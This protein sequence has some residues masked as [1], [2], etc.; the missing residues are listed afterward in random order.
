MSSVDLIL[1]AAG[2]MLGVG[3]LTVLA[4]F[5]YS[6]Y[7]NYVERRLATRKGLYRDLVA[8]LANR[9]RALLEPTIHQMSTLYDLDALEAVL[10]EQARTSTGRPAWLLEVYDQLGLVDKYID[11]LR[12]ARKWRDRAFAAELLGRVGSAKAVPALLETVQA[13]QTEDADVREIALRALARI[14]DPQAVGPLIAALANADPWL[15]PRIADILARH[16]D[17]VV[18]PLLTLLTDS[19]RHPARVW[20]AN[21]LGEVRAQRAFPVLVR[22]LDDP[23]DEVRAKSATALGRLGDRR[24][25]SPLLDHLLTDPAPFV[26]VRIACTLGD[27]G[28]SEVVNRLVRALGDPAWWVRMRGVEALEQI[29][30]A[31]EGPLLLALDDPDPEIRKRAAASLERLGVPA[32][33]LHSIE[34]EEPSEE[35]SRTLVRLASASSRELVAELLRHPS[36]RVRGLMLTAARESHRSDLAP[37]IARVATDDP[38]PG[39]R[40]QAFDTLARVRSRG[41]GRSALKG[42]A[43]PDPEVRTAAIRLLGEVGDHAVLDPLRHATRDPEPTIRAAAA[44][45]LGKIGDRAAEPDFLRLL[46][47]PDSKVRE[48]A[49]DGAAEAGIQSL[50]PALQERLTDSEGPV[51]G[52]ELRTALALALSRLD[53]NAATH[54]V[55]RLAESSDAASRIAA[56]RLLGR[57]RLPSGTPQWERL[58]SDGEPDVRAA[59]LEALGRDARLSG[60]SDILLRAVTAGLSDSSETVRARAIDVCSRKCLDEHSRTLTSLLQDDPAATVR[61]RA[62]LAL[63]LL[64]AHG[65]ETVLTAACRR[66]QSPDVRAA[67]ALAAGAYDRNSLVTLMLEMPDSGAVRARLRHYLKADPW[68]RLLSRSLPRASEAELRALAAD[69]AVESQVTLATGVR[70]LLSASERVRLIT[71]LQAFRGEQSRDALLQLV[72]SDP[73]AEVRAAALTAVGELLDPDELLAFGS[74][75]LGDPDVV[76]RRTAVSLF[77]RVPP[78]RAFPRLMKAMRVDDDPAVL[79]AAARLA[80]EHFSTFRD[81]IL[82]QSIGVEQSVLAARVSRYLHHPELPMLLSQLARNNAPEVREA[83]AEVFRHRPDLA[84]PVALEGITTDPVVMVRRIA[85][86]AAAAAERYDLLD[87]M[88][89]DPEVEVRREVAIALGRAA[90]VQQGGVVVLEHLETDSDMSIRAAAHVARLLQGTPVPLP[91]NLDARVAAEAVRDGADIGMLRNLA[92]T[93]LSEDRRLAA[94]LALALLQ[95]EVAKDVARSDPAPAVRHRVAGALELSLP[96]VHSE[97]A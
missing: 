78:A 42:M 13:T 38:E 46:D 15:A 54:L 35:P 36:T 68:F 39:L 67:A 6:A 34:S 47:D 37:E 90:P 65:G 7:L 76:V 22:C 92:R 23:D 9:D 4:W 16:G 20:A 73:S 84:E 33:L 96:G 72:R 86:G 55:A 87:R 53:P 49:M 17:V 12:T 63:G 62:A 40:A 61:Q 64:R 28:G 58:A 25:V 93:A 8:E 79:V 95:D 81:A 45:A 18:D 60:P 71:G 2:V 27:F 83:V 21:V 74:R 26:R 1:V 44:R 88:T 43:D 50:A 85:V 59:T 56:A 3:L 48:A 5:V 69:T 10:E 75:A 57:L 29:G 32:G 41:A 77:G 80:E 91:P 66:D 89:Q 51:G 11:K 82:A 94:A 14:A 19:S 52:S 70:S 31:A 24:A 97:P 30:P